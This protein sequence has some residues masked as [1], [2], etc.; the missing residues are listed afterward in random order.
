MLRVGIVGAGQIGAKR[1][2]VIARDPGAQ[3]IWVADLDGERARALAAQYGSRAGSDW[4]KFVAAPETDAIVVATIHKWLAPISLAAL[5]SGKHVLCEKPLA[6]IPKDAQRL[7]ESAAQHGATLKTGFNHRHHPAVKQAHALAKAGEIGDLLFIRCRYGHGGRAGYDKEWRADPTLSGGGQL[8]DQGIHCLDL[9]RWFL[10]EFSDVYAVR[11][12]P[13]WPMPVE[14]NVFC[15]LRTPSGQVASLHASWTQ[16]K[17]LFSFEVFG[18]NG[19]LLAEG[20]GGYYGRERLTFGRRPS[21]FGVPEERLTEYGGDDCS[22]QEEWQ[23]FVSA[24]RDH[25]APLADG[26]DGWRALLL[27]QAA[28]RSME[29]KQ[30]IF[31]E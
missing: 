17:N 4:E 11:P 13:F 1:A 24:I 12:R 2:Q 27:V 3:L 9:F 18:D 19:Y 8:L 23:E 26:C 15:T 29:Q 14:D 28:Y 31:L 25:R 20:L 6:T 22:W 7:V 10:G 5:E 30:V 21:C 16:W